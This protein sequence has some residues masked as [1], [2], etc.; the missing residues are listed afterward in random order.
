M[1]SPNAYPRNHPVSVGLAAVAYAVCFRVSLMEA[2]TERAR[3]VG[4]AVG[5]D[6]FD[7]AAEVVGLPYCR[8]LDLYVDKQ[9]KARAE[10]LHFTQAHHA[11]GS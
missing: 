1:S 7:R 3:Y 6:C 2:L 8:T 9:T 10:A 5:S 4:V 11:L